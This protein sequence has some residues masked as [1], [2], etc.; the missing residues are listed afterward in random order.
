MK[1]KNKYFILIK[2]RFKLSYG[3]YR[4]NARN[5]YYPHETRDITYKWN[6]FTRLDV[7]NKNL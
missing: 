2:I 5:Y 1:V 3:Y 6:Q 7:I 4:K